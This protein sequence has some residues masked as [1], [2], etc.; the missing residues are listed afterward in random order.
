MI[1]IRAL[2]REGVFRTSATL[3][4]VLWL[5]LPLAS[6][7]NA[8]DV[9][10][11][12]P[13]TFA[14]LDGQANDSDGLVNGVLV[15]D[16]LTI[17]AGGSITNNDPSCPGNASAG[18]M[19]IIVN[20]NLF[21]QAESSITAENTI[22]GGSGGD[23]AILVS[24][25]MTLEGADGLNPGA[26]ISSRK[27]SGSG[28]TGHSGDI[29]IRAFLLTTFSGSA[30]TA[31]Q[32]MGTDKGSAGAIDI[33]GGFIDIGGEVSSR[34]GLTSRGR[35]ED[36]EKDHGE[37][38]SRSRLTGTG[39]HQAPGGGTITVDS[40]FN[41]SV[42]PT[43]VISSRGSDPGADL[44]HL[45][46]PLVYIA[47]LVESTSAGHAVPRY[48]RNHLSGF[49][50]PDK[51]C[52]SMGGVEVWAEFI[53]ID[54]FSP[55]AV[56]EINADIGTCGGTH[57]RGWIDLFAQFEVDI[58]GSSAGPFAV[59]ANGGL[60]QNT[61]DGGIVTIKSVSGNLFATGLAVQADSTNAGQMGRRHEDDEDD[62]DDEDD[63]DSTTAVEMGRRHE[64]DEHDDDSTNAGGMGGVITLEAWGDMLMDGASLFARGDFVACG[65]YG[66]GGHIA[67]K[68]F[69][70]MLNWTNG[71]GDVRPTGSSVPAQRR[72]A[73]SLVYG[74]M[75]DLTGTTFPA[76]GTATT[77]NPPSLNGGGSPS[78]PGY[79]ILP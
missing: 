54:R 77:P 3:C 76:N 44:V 74:T 78:L 53:T 69:N 12:V 17:L 4:A 16:N 6:Q 7:A 61:D 33:E 52:N 57:G 79:V 48:P 35:G 40:E 43:G 11:S 62:K 21:M 26:I 66:H 27:R 65:G 20:G 2:H 64:D 67:V 71:S 24:G 22:S 46:A 28:D 13:T 5:M 34:S 29:S 55:G 25:G 18:P 10:I 56:G 63:E 9:T 50:R 59:H 58:F 38:S 75:F 32:V 73:I 14:G 31:G 19:T 51:P 30:I 45:E 49:Y 8:V 37:V 36:D 47:G 70:G 23:I 15:V 42:E 39:C 1:I 41:L 72:G 60:S 68:S